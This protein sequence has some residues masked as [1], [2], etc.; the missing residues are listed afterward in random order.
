MQR[1]SSN[2]AVAGQLGADN[3]IMNTAN[4]DTGTTGRSSIL[5]KRSADKHLRLRLGLLWIAA[6]GMLSTGIVIANADE[7]TSADAYRLGPGDEIFIYVFGEEDLSMD[8]RLDDTGTLNYPLL[9]ELLLEGLT[10]TELEQLIT[11][12]LKGPFLID[13]DVTVSITEYRPFFLNGE[14]HEPGGIPYQPGLTLEK[15]IT[16]GGG[17]TERASRKKITVIRDANPEGTAVAI[18][19]NDPVY[20]G[21]VITVHQ[22][23]F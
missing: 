6:T 13:P 11:Q 18:E 3:K 17:F 19:L 10:V 4:A 8:F 23:F 12:R 1:V 22:S 14:V 21:D 5:T 7:L 20:A 2:V 15:A 9:G 16:L